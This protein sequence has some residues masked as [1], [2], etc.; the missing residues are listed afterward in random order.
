VFR[1]HVKPKSSANLLVLMKIFPEMAWGDYEY[2]FNIDKE[3]K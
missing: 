1:A 3:D 2:Q